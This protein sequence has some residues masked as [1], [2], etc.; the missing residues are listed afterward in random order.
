MAAEESNRGTGEEKRDAGAEREPPTCPH[1][2]RSYCGICE[3]AHDAAGDV[4]ER[5]V[6][7]VRRLAM[8]DHADGCHAGDDYPCICI[9]GKAIA[10]GVLSLP[11]S[12][13]TE[14][15]PETNE[16]LEP[17]TVALRCS[18]GE[19]TYHDLVSRPEDETSERRA[20]ASRE[21]SRCGASDDLVVCGACHRLLADEENK[22]ALG[23]V[24]AERDK[25]VA[26]IAA[27]ARALGM[28]AG[29]GSHDPKDA[30]W[31]PAW[32]NIVFIDLPTSQ[33][34]WHVHERERPWFDGLGAYDGAWDGHTT[35]EKYE[36]VLGAAR[37]LTERKAEDADWTIGGGR[38]NSSPLYLKLADEI[39][40]MVGSTRVGDDPQG[41]GRLILSQLAHV[42]GLAPRMPVDPVASFRAWAHENRESLK[43]PQELDAERAA[44]RAEDGGP[45]LSL[46]DYADCTVTERQGAIAALEKIM[47]LVEHGSPV[48][49]IASEQHAWLASERTTNDDLNDHLVEKSIWDEAIEAAVDTVIDSLDAG[50]SSVKERLVDKLRSMKRFGGAKLV[51]ADGRV[52]DVT[53]AGASSTSATATMAGLNRSAIARGLSRIAGC[54]GGTDQHTET[55]TE[56][57]PPHRL[58]RR[59]NEAP[60][61]V[62]FGNMPP[63]A[64][65]PM[66]G[67]SDPMQPCTFERGH[68]GACSYTLGANAPRPRQ[69]C[70]TYHDRDGA[71]WCCQRDEGHEGLHRDVDGAWP[72]VLH[73]DEFVGTIEER[74]GKLVR[75]RLGR[76]YA[77]GPWFD[78]EAWREDGTPCMRCHQ[79]LAWEGDAPD[80]AEDAIC[81]ACTWQ[82]LQAAR[83]QVMMLRR[84]MGWAEDRGTSRAVVLEAM[85]RLAS[86]GVK[87]RSAAHDPNETLILALLRRVGGHAG[88]TK[89]DLARAAQTQL[90]RRDDGHT[91]EL[92]ARSDT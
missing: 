23:D 81:S 71:K 73:D 17:G 47:A 39:A 90:V 37:E 60:D 59:P 22:A 74:F 42:H 6:A 3:A 30:S 31:D 11:K 14:I 84:A 50:L 29:L 7:F 2:Y 9:V 51:H 75:N 20:T 46:A 67:M 1:G 8:R 91:L 16:K 62:T 28:T 78:V 43:T 80:C 13:V 40:R 32:R 45:T 34:S 92:T 57:V 35:A 25:C 19:I 55:C 49:C 56:P 82:E 89:N 64:P 18:C 54:C 70:R 38:S 69:Q 24:Y 79:T 48:H 86:L 61:A 27:M 12:T 72:A 58:S 66:A 65:C 77:S 5:V 68:A 85:I 87:G 53:P 33:V 15:D 52:E 26:L 10:T 41:R 63:R 44:D 88:F 36:R 4:R 21:C 76:G 83:E